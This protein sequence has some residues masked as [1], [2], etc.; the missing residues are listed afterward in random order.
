MSND[1][2]MDQVFHAFDKD[3]GGFLI[4]ENWVR[5]MPIFLKGTLDEK[6]LLCYNK[7]LACMV[8][9]TRCS[10]NIIIVIYG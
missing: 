10:Y 4:Q 2:I 6:K 9:R 5:G 7:Q 8:L 1:F 3:S